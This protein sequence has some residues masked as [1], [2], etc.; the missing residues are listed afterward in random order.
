MYMTPDGTEHLGDDV[1]ITANVHKSLT[2]V[3]LTLLP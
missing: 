3:E 2:L 1:Q